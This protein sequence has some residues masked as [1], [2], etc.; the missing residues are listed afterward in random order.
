MPHALYEFNLALREI[1]D[2]D[3]RKI[4]V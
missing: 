4:L 2:V 3:S 1:A